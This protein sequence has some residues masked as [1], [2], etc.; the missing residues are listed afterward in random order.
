MA[1]FINCL[2]L[3]T[4]IWALQL[5]FKYEY[6]FFDTIII[7]EARMTFA[8]E[9]KPLYFEKYRHL[10]P[11]PENKIIYDVIDTLPIENDV[12]YMTASGQRVQGNRWPAEHAMRNHCMSLLKEMDL[13]DEDLIAI[14][15]A[16]EIGNIEDMAKVGPTLAPNDVYKLGY[17]NYKASVHPG[18]YQEKLWL[19]GCLFRA[20]L[21]EE[22]Y[23]GLRRLYFNHDVDSLGYWHIQSPLFV[24]KLDG[25]PMY[26]FIKRPGLNPRRAERGESPLG[27]HFSSMSGGF[28]KLRLHKGQS[29]AHAE[30][31]SKTIVSSEDYW[32]EVVAFT[33]EM[34]AAGKYD[35]TDL[36]EHLP[37]FVTTSIREFPILLLPKP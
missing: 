16:D 24:S 2:I 5:R 32:A 27:W 22:D 33:D 1:K 25:S 37:D 17:E 4:E 29:F 14:Q 10:F 15:D 8:G 28:Q 18:G 3:N 34:A 26:H 23:H 6:D 19:G 11:D 20:T 30:Y 7:T 35:Y 12:E 9:T 31:S 36:S 21:L 13:S